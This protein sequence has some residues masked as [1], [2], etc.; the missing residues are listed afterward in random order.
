MYTEFFRLFAT[1]TYIGGKHIDISN[2]NGS[3]LVFGRYTS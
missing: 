1:F 2:Q 3:L